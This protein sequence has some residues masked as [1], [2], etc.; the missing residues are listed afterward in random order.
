MIEIKGDLFN[1]KADAIAITTNGTV[2]KAGRAVMGR[3]VAKIAKETW[4]DIDMTL[5]N[6]ISVFGNHVHSLY[7]DG[8][9][10]ICVVS[11]PVKH[12]WFEK[13]DPKLIEQSCR[14]LRELADA[15][16]W[17]YV[18]LPRPGC[19]NGQLEWKDVQPLVANEL[20]DRFVVVNNEEE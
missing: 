16:G 6:D 12:S 7:Y 18:V 9:R 14:E 17:K 5:G 10:Q 8:A 4:E 15:Q 1:Q 11:F 3:G 19:G 2:T 13:A 20:D